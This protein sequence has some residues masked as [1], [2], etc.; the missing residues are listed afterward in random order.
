MEKFIY[1]FGGV[2]TGALIVSIVVWKKI[3]KY[4]SIKELTTGRK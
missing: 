4:K 2:I 1:F 3:R